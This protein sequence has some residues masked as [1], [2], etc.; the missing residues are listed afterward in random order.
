MGLLANYTY[1]SSETIFEFEDQAITAPLNG[2]SKDSYNATLYYENDLWGARVSVNDRSDYSTGIPGGNGNLTEATSGLPHYDFSAFF[3][4]TEN[5]VLTLE[6]INLTDEAERLFT[7][8][9]GD[10]DLVREYNKTG[11]EFFLGARVNF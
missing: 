1:V 6:V 4:L 11:R 3:N 8:G 2:L 7:T 10:L 5:I 9:D